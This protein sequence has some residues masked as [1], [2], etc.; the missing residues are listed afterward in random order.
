M[1]LDQVKE[2]EKLFS[3]DQPSLAALSYALRHKETWPDWFQWDFGDCFQC[4]MGLSLALWKDSIRFPNS[5]EMVRVFGMPFDKATKI[6]G[7]NDWATFYGSLVW[8][9][10]PE[11]VADKIDEYLAESRC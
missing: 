6:F 11:Q 10:T 9:I 5:C 7:G 1:R 3:L 8:R 2:A 4:A